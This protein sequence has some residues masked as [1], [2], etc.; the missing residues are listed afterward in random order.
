MGDVVVVPLAVDECKFAGF[1]LG[2]LRRQEGLMERM[3]P[4]VNH[5]RG[6]V[7]MK[8]KFQQEVTRNRNGVADDCARVSEGYYKMSVLI[9]VCLPG[10]H[11]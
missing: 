5:Q 2:H 4:C 7:F 1:R 8:A 11:K 3:F 10:H 9:G 6:E